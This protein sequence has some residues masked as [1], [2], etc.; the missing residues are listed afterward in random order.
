[1]TSLP[2]GSSDL[3][4]ATFK[5]IRNMNLMRFQTTEGEKKTEKQYQD[6]KEEMENRNRLLQQNLLDY[7]L[8]IIQA[9]DT[10]KRIQNENGAYWKKQ[11]GWRQEKIDEIM[12]E[13]YDPELVWNIEGPTRKKTD[14]A[15]RDACNEEIKRVNANQSIG[16]SQR[17][18]QERL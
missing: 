6:L 7:K 3:A 18:N 10:K 4:Q 2:A 8:S 14:K 12:K 13:P 5:M 11:M 15:H 16:L 17:I 1:M 9:K